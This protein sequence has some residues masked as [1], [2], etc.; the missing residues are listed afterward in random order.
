MHGKGYPVIAAILLILG[1]M[2][3]IHG[4]P[5][6][7]V[8]PLETNQFTDAAAFAALVDS[9]DFK[10]DYYRL[11]SRIYIEWGRIFQFDSDAG[12]I[13]LYSPNLQNIDTRSYSY[14]VA[15]FDPGNHQDVSALIQF[16]LLEGWVL[17]EMYLDDDETWQCRATAPYDDGDVDSGYWF[18]NAAGEVAVQVFVEVFFEIL[19]LLI[20]SSS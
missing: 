17:E 7:E 14:R 1:V 8:T 6:V 3:C 20:R 19:E 12:N 11:D 9:R 5:V 10:I 13:L 4:P 18:E 16:V 15:D 2:G